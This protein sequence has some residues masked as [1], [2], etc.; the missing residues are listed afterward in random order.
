MPQG[1]LKQIRST[2][3]DPMGKGLIFAKIWD[4]S[5]KNI[6]TKVIWG[7][8]FFELGYPDFLLLY[9]KERKILNRFAEGFFFT[10]VF[11]KI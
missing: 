7:K 5:G 8:I 1:V 11:N 4:K 3:E 10:N 9:L 2:T 6:W